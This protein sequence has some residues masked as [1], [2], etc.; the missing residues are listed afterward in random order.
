MA[1]KGT[2]Q[3]PGRKAPRSGYETYKFWY[4]R[5]ASS[6]EMKS[7]IYN[8]RAYEA[9][10][11]RARRAGYKTENFSR[12]LAMRQREA[13]ELQLRVTYGIAKEKIK[14]AKNRL[15]INKFEIRKNIIARAKGKGKKLSEQDITERI[16]RQLRRRFKE[17][18]TLVKEFGNIKYSE[19][20]KR[21]K[22]IVERARQTVEDRMEWDE[23]FALAFDSPKERRV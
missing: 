20:R 16:N 14:E 17:D 6:V 18:Y 9:I 15:D 11:E 4:N 19:F 3:K 8:E 12:I 13:S 10:R 1:M 23:A 21:Q 2:K 5:Y 7:A 22:E